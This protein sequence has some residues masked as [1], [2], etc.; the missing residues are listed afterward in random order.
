MR[1]L[2]QALLAL[3]KA[4]EDIVLRPAAFSFDQA[5]AF[6]ILAEEI[7]AAD[8]RPC[9]GERLT[10]S[11]MA[12]VMFIENFYGERRRAS[13]WQSRIGG[14]IPYLREDAFRQFENERKQL[15]S[16]VSR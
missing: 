14:E 2:S 12:V 4:A 8:N 7:R 5:Q 1:P 3:I 16:E 9:E 10:Y 11:A 6:N 13:H 15:N